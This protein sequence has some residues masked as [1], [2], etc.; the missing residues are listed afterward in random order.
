MEN[1]EKPFLS[2]TMSL[3]SIISLRKKH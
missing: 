3:A 2:R 1:M